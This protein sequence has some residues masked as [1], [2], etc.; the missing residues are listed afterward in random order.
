MEV[1]LSVFI[2]AETE[3]HHNGDPDLAFQLVGSAVAAS[4]TQYS[5]KSLKPI[6]FQLKWRRGRALSISGL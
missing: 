1:K 2:I 6:A 3:V 4:A 5:C